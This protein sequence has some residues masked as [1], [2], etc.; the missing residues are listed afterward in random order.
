MLE[1]GI[2]PALPHG[3]P[4]SFSSFPVACLSLVLRA[5]HT[6][7]VRPLL[8]RSATLLA[9]FSC[10]QVIRRPA[11]PIEFCRPHA[12]T[13]LELDP[14]HYLEVISC[15][16]QFA[17]RLTGDPEHATTL[18]CLQRLVVV[19]CLLTLAAGAGVGGGTKKFRQVISAC[20][21]PPFWRAVWQHA[22][23]LGVGYRPGLTTRFAPL[24]FLRLAFPWSSERHTPT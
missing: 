13:G 8:F 17:F 22:A 1:W 21:A 9:F 6:D 24:L 5:A 16:A 4:H 3:S 23:F 2:D 20:R 7:L 19:A 12:P 10:F 11:A 15:T 18:S 14:F